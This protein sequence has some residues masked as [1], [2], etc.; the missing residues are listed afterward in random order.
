MTT[1]FLHLNSAASLTGNEI[2]PLQ[3]AGVTL[4]STSGAIAQLASSLLSA[5]P[6]AAAVGYNTLTFGP[7][8]TLGQNW[9]VPNF[10][11]LGTPGPSSQNADGSVAL[12]GEVTGSGADI[13]TMFLLPG[14]IP[15]GT[16]FG[17]GAYMEILAA[18][19]PAIYGTPASLPM[20]AFWAEP[21]SLLIG[22]PT[23]WPG[24]VA[25]YD[26]WVELDIAQYAHDSLQGYIAT[27][28][29]HWAGPGA[30]PPVVTNY[31]GAS[32]QTGLR[33]GPNRD[34]VFTT[35]SRPNR[36][37]CLWVTA[38]ADGS[39]QGYLQNYLN[40]VLTSAISSPVPIVWN[41]YNPALA[42]PPVIGSTQGALLDQQQMV[43]LAGTSI[44]C[45]MTVYGVQVWQA[46]S[47][48]NLVQ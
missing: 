17:G 21:T 35:L 22:P 15:K 27:S 31:G 36:Y 16:A 26:E 48:G 5:P 2:I 3:Q 37:G 33:T 47:A 29:A 12:S 11:A 34:G 43:L 40:G 10:A 19:N 39:R 38:A 18:F 25:G 1:D 20:P 42:P 23:Q 7:N 30:H 8:V 46:S 13:A 28:T 14:N 9:F 41:L 6:Q 24:Q 32:A 4:R 45:P 44:Q